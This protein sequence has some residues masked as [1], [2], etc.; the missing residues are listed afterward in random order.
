VRRTTRG[1][2]IGLVGVAAALLRADVA[3]AGTIT[4][5]NTNPFTVS[6]DASGKPAAFTIVATGFTP[7]T[8]VSVEQCDGTSPSAPGWSPLTNCDLGS[9]PSQAIVADDGTVTF[10]ASDPNHAF[11]PF[12]G[13][14]PQSLFNCSAAGQAPPNNGLP[15]FTNCQVR[16]ASNTTVV[17]ADQA[18]ITMSLPK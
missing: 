14:S 13:E 18:F 6:K 1:A 15:N 5:P 16:V 9:S 11:R 12:K 3:F 2:V 7:G 4:T 17:T 8:L 10:S